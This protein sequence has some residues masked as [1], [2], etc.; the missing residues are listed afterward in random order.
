MSKLHL[1]CPLLSLFSGGMQ[2]LNMWWIC[3]FFGGVVDFLWAKN[4][5]CTVFF[6]T[7]VCGKRKLQGALQSINLAGDDFDICHTE[8]VGVVLNI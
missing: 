3:Y 7:R 2:G 6:S 8:I 5:V 4:F 1:K